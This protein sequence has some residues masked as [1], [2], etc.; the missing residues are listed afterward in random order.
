MAHTPIKNYAQMH[1]D[2]FNGNDPGGVLWQPRLEFWYEVN[3][4]RG[5]LPAQLKNAS[6]IEVY[7]YCHASIRYFAFPLKLLHHHLEI[8]ESWIDAKSLKKVWQTQWGEL[9]EIFHYDEWGIS[10]EIPPDGDIERVRQTGEMV[11]RIKFSH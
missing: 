5:T 11:E 8:Q 9:S 1:L 6:L 2:I 10:D 4:K 3:R 7:D